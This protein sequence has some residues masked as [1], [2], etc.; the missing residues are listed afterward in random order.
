MVD[1]AKFS[2]PSQFKGKLSQFNIRCF[3]AFIDLAFLQ[4]QTKRRLLIFE[5]TLFR[6]Q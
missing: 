1:I 4:S 3:S 6:F 2:K 5:T